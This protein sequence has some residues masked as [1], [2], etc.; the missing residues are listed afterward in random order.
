MMFFTLLLY[1]F[2]PFQ[3]C[4]LT[5]CRRIWSKQASCYNRFGN[6]FWDTLLSELVKVM[7]GDSRHRLVTYLRSQTSLDLAREKGV[8]LLLGIAFPVEVWYTKVNKN[9]ISLGMICIRKTFR[10]ETFSCP[11]KLSI[12]AANGSYEDRALGSRKKHLL[13]WDGI[14]KA[15]YSLAGSHNNYGKDE[16]HEKNALPCSMCCISSL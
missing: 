2:G 14:N 6:S 15:I 13:M 7:S 3:D 16:S 9:R 12:F 4:I 5:K 1:W 10:E 11:I 8:V